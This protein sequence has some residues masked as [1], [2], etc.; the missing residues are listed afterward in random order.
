MVRYDL[1]GQGTGRP[2]LVQCGLHFHV[3][4]GTLP[5]CQ[6]L[7]DVQQREHMWLEDR[8]Q[9]VACRLHCAHAAHAQDVPTAVEGGRSPKRN[10]ALVYPT[11]PSFPTALSWPAP[12]PRSQAL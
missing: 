5:C 7:S 11:V 10:G 2:G 8:D 12:P 6:K 4:A 1:Q 9:A 3:V